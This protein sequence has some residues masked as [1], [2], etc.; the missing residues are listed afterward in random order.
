VTCK[1]L[2]S[3]ILEYLEN[4]LDGTTR[5]TFDQHLSICPNC[6][7]YLAHYRATIALEQNAFR[8]PS[9]ALPAVIPESW[10]RALL[11]ACR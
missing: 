2:A 4:E 7:R 3:F 8:E 11:A 1:E 6:V 10:V 5:A 9:T